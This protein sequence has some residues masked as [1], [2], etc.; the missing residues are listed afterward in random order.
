MDRGLHSSFILFVLY[1]IYFH[2][3]N[4]YTYTINF[5]YY[6]K[7]KK[8]ISL[9]KKIFLPPSDTFLRYFHMFHPALS[10]SS[11]QLIKYYYFS[12]SFE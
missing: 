6:K 7:K 11:L 12:Y 10:L 2:N 5:S 9:R 4:V 3:S 8:N 1:F